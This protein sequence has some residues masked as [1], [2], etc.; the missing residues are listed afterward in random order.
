MRT[1]CTSPWRGSITNLPLSYPSLF[2]LQTPHREAASWGVPLHTVPG[3]PLLTRRCIQPNMP[4][5]PAQRLWVSPQ[6]GRT[7][8]QESPVPP[9][10]PLATSWGPRPT[11]V[12]TRVPAKGVTGRGS[13]RGDKMRSVVCGQ[14]TPRP[15]SC[16]TTRWWHEQ[17]PRPHTCSGNLDLRARKQGSGGQHCVQSAWPP[18]SEPRCSRPQKEPRKRAKTLSQGIRGSRCWPSLEHIN[19]PRGQTREPPLSDG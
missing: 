7:P 3:Q 13:R 4:L 1:G 8:N 10:A 15:A 2:G 16:H 11:V 14:M 17:L 12:R 6:W 18:D 19:K 9:S 5:D